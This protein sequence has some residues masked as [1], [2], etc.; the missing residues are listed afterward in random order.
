MFISLTVGLIHFFKAFICFLISVN[1]F[2]GHYPFWIDAN[3]FDFFNFLLS[4]L[5]VS[6]ILGYTRIKDDKFKNNT[7]KYNLDSFD[8]NKNYQNFSGLIN[9]E[10]DR[11]NS[12]LQ[13]PFAQDLN[14]P[15]LDKLDKI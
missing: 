4:E 12:N 9:R 10:N 5:F 3:L 1:H 6:L 14:D 2:K 11:N 7:D 15:L 13:N 8:F